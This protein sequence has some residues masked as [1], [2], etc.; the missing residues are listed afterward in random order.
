MNLHETTEYKVRGRERVSETWIPARGLREGCS[1]LLILFN[2]YYQIVMRQAEEQR[3]S[4][5]D[6]TGIVCK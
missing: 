2:V 3:Q 5:N 1:T 6:A 4:V